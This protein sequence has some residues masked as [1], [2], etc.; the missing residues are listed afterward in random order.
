MIAVRCAALPLVLALGLSSTAC[1][2]RFTALAQG[3]VDQAAVRSL[4][5]V[6]LSPLQIA[7]QPDYESA[8]VWADHTQA[9]SDAFHARVI[10][11]SAGRDGHRVQLLPPGA[12]V[13]SGLVIVVTVRE[14]RK[15][16]LGFSGEHVVADVTLL[17]ARSG[18]KALTATL[19]VSARRVAAGFEGYTFGGR[20]KFAFLNLADAIVD[21]LDRGHFES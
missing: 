14:V 21:A 17:D 16:D 10:S 9:W 1:A 18:K 8:E 2:P 15:A 7:F 20:V 6:Y 4:S 3:P 13:A 19:D 5:P 12:A 11:A